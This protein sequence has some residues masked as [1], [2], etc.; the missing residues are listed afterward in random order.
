MQ[1]TPLYYNYKT[2]TLYV[3]VHELDM[4]TS[5][6]TSKESI[7]GFPIPLYTGTA[8]EHKL[9]ESQIV[10]IKNQII[11]KSETQIQS[12]SNL[13]IDSKEIMVIKESNNRLELIETV[14]FDSIETF[15]DKSNINVP[16]K[17]GERLHLF[18]K[19]KSYTIKPI[20]DK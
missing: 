10:E 2:S 20:A 6:L 5:T 13:E 7:K 3:Y 9:I 11:S 4:I 8:E 18:K 14:V 17:I 16:V 1:C 12:K 15:E 19:I